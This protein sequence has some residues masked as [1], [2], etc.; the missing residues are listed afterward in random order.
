[1]VFDK[2]FKTD[3]LLEKYYHVKVRSGSPPH[4]DRNECKL[5]GNR[6]F[7]VLQTAAQR[8]CK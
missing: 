6:A 2:N 8:H 1:M 4:T 5:E 7:F 3:N